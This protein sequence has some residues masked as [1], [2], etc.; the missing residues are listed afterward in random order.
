[1]RPQCPQPALIG[2][3]A[4]FAAECVDERGRRGLRNALF[5]IE[6]GSQP[7]V[8]ADRFLN[9]VEGEAQ[10]ARGDRTVGR[11]REP[12]VERVLADRRVDR[13]AQALQA[14]DPVGEAITQR[15][16]EWADHGVR[17]GR[18]TGAIRGAL[19]RR[20]EWIE[21][22]LSGQRPGRD[23]A[24]GAP[25]VVD[26]LPVFADQG[27]ALFRFVEAGDGS[28][29]R[30]RRPLARIGRELRRVAIGRRDRQQRA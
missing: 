28:V 25:G 8:D 17:V 29:D 14:F 26:A 18:E 30:R 22:R 2:R 21:Q 16:G 19:D 27:L 1:M 9:V 5:G 3:R 10:H 11:D 13:E 20:N 7:V 24:V 6:R 12:Q 4:R 23:F 15:V